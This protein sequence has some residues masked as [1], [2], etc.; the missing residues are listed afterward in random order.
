M[1]ASSKSAADSQS[2]PEE[3]EAS[4]LEKY[5]LLKT[6]E[7]SFGILLSIKEVVFAYLACMMSMH[8]VSFFTSF[9]AIVFENQY[10]IAEDDMGYYFAV[11]SGPYLI[12]AITFPIF[13][14]KLPRK[15]CFTICPLVSAIAVG[16]MGPSNLLGLPEKNLPLILV[17]MFILGYVQIFCFIPCIPEVMDAV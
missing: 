12:A 11:L 7:I 8:C 5:N 13:F 4:D 9:L 6:S 17:G 10:K 14:G 16:M 1:T 15:L 2:A 3:T